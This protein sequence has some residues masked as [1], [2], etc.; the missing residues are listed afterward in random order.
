MPPSGTKPSGFTW[1]RKMHRSSPR[2]R[3]SAVCS[4]H[5][6]SALAQRE[7]DPV[8][9]GAVGCGA[10]ARPRIPRAPWHPGS[11]S[12]SAALPKD[13]LSSIL[14]RKSDLNTPGFLSRYFR[15]R[16]MAEAET[17]YVA[18]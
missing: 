13:E 4:T 10:G 8:P 5:D 12:T 6:L 1:P 9:A 15:D 11:P 17:Q 14:G 16:V 3:N 7:R 2:F 18:A